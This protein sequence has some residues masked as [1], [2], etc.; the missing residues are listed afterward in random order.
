[1][2]WH[3]LRSVPESELWAKSS[4]VGNPLK[5]LFSGKNL[6]HFGVAFVTSTGAWLILDGTIGVFGGHF[7]KLG[8]DPMHRQHH[9]ARRS[10]R[11]RRASSRSSAP[12]ARSTAADT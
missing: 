9:R 5:A 11:R 2:F 1:M 12:P 7:K 8:T 3:Y 10:R 4:N 6:R